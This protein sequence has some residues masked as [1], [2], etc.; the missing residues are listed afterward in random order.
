M[1]FTNY[2]SQGLIIVPL[3]LVFGWFDRV[4]PS[5]GLLLAGAFALLQLLFSTW[6]LR[7]HSAGPFERMWRRV[8]YLS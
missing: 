1:A 2:L 8:T 4:T 7:H 5:R 3:C 6:W